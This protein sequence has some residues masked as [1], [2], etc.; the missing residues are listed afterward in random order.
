MHVYLF[1]FTF[2]PPANYNMHVSQVSTVVCILPCFYDLPLRVLY[3]SDNK[4]K[5]IG[6]LIIVIITYNAA[7]TKCAT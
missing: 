3:A 7:Q 1:K 4:I 5:L 2:F 6:L